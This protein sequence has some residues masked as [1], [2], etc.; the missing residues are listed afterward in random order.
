MEF[1]PVTV[2]I[3][4][5]HDSGKTTLMNLIR[6]MLEEN[7]YKQVTVKDVEPLP[8]EHKDRFPDRFERNRIL[9]PVRIVVELEK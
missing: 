4:G 3:R 6:G 8:A 1:D 7:G 2:T 9:R 5:K